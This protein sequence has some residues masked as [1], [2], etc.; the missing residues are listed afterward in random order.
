MLCAARTFPNACARDQPAARRLRPPP[1]RGG[2]AVS[3]PVP[4]RP[5]AARPALAPTPRGNLK[6]GAPNGGCRQRDRETTREPSRPS[7]RGFPG[8]AP[9]PTRA[10]GGCSGSERRPSRCCSAAA[11][12]AACLPTPGAGLG[13]PAGPGGGPGGRRARSRVGLRG[14]WV[15]AIPE[16]G[17]RGGHASGAQPRARFVPGLRL[18]LRT[19]PRG[20]PR[21]PPAPAGGKVT[22]AGREPG[23][24]RRGHGSA[25][26]LRAA[27]G[28]RGRGEEA[29]DAGCSRGS[30]PPFAGDSEARPSC[31]GAHAQR[32]RREHR[33]PRRS[34]PGCGGGAAAGLRTGTCS[35]PSGPGVGATPRYGC[36]Q[37]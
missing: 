19:P 24:R 25:L 35:Q 4:R 33:P 14:L 10:G 3:H 29:A 27:R 22:L 17:Q 9:P 36:P 30:P 1:T 32:A 23:A 5:C 26:V 37:R 16:T 28:R 6:H 21:G 34:D 18:A 8:G 20:D 12:G 15:P 13:A 7:R 2:A 31:A 11:G